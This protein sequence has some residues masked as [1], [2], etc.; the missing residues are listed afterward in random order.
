M[1]PGGSKRALLLLT[2]PLQFMSAPAC[3]TWLLPPV[4]VTTER[5]KERVQ[6]VRTGKSMGNKKLNISCVWVTGWLSAG[7]EDTSS[8]AFRSHCN[9]D[10][11]VNTISAL[12]PVCCLWSQILSSSYIVF[13]GVN[14][15]IKK[16]REK[17]VKGGDGSCFIWA[18]LSKIFHLLV[19]NWL[20][21]SSWGLE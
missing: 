21:M 11:V 1:C 17:K 14:V 5:R 20:G 10:I 15:L 4:P 16:S 12:Q 18:S 7:H 19:R 6:P 8:D 3:I 9:H 13:W 2:H